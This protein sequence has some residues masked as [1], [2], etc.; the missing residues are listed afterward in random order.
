MSNTYDADH[1]WR[2]M[3]AMLERLGLD[4]SM[5]AHGR[6]A[7]DLRSAVTNCQS[8]AA[9]QAC[10]EW[11]VRAPEAIDKP[12]AFCPNA[13]LFASVRDLIERGV[14]DGQKS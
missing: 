5:L 6:L 10:Q 7:S 9:D 8:C 3:C 11:L 13:E 4:A 2:N 12:P 1:R 14:D